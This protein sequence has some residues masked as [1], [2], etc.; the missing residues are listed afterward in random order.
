MPMSDAHGSSTSP[1]RRIWLVW[2][3]IALCTVILAGA[4]AWIAFRPVRIVDY[5]AMYQIAIERHLPPGAHNTAERTHELVLSLRQAIQEAGEAAS[6]IERAKLP[7]GEVEP[8]YIE[9]SDF[10]AIPLRPGS[11][12]DAG[13]VVYARLMLSLL[14]KA[15]AWQDIDSIEYG[16]IF[17]RDLGESRS[18]ADDFDI[19][20]CSP[21]LRR[22]MSALQ[23]RMYEQARAGNGEGAVRSFVSGMTFA[24]AYA[25]LGLVM[26]WMLGASNQTLL[27]NTMNR[28]IDDDLLS[29]TDLEYF[30]DSLNSLPTVIPLSE[31]LKFEHIYILAGI[32]REHI[33]ASPS[34]RLRHFVM[35]RPG[36]ADTERASDRFFNQL[37]PIFDQPGHSR[38]RLSLQD[39]DR[40]ILDDLR[41]LSFIRTP[42]QVRDGL[43]CRLDG[44]GLYV[45]IERYRLANGGRPPRS[46]DD[47]V[48]TFLP[49]IPRDHY[50]PDG[51]FRYTVLGD[52]YTLYSIGLDRTDDGGTPPPPGEAADFALTPDGAGTDYLIRRQVQHQTNE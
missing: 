13:D 9:Y 7:P 16:P 38:P 32:Q 25:R 33:Q 14:D 46:L 47:L 41:L 37:I 35:Q 31:S 17:V 1:P 6:E 20:Y 34:E 40:N 4:A 18:L 36:R 39:Q 19:I 28:I 22:C 15:G 3:L 23:A 45:A 30:A 12:D 27:I 21:Q 26:D 2:K 29:S 5:R 43:T 10:Q 11:S 50:A 24:I 52:T 51:A 49:T 44:L 8:D 48:P 42:A